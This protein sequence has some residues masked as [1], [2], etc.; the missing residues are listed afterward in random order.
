MFAY[1]AVMMVAEAMERTKSTEGAKVI[2][3]LFKLGTISGA[4]GTFRVTPNGE[5]DTTVFIGTWSPAGKVELIR[6]WDPPKLD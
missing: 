2:P 4:G 5:I 3:E 6:A 1:D